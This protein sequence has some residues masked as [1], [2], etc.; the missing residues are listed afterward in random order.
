[1]FTN[2]YFIFGS[3]LVLV[4]IS[5]IAYYNGKKINAIN[6]NVYNYTAS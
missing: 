6:K 1:M 4:I 5:F 3:I 2:K